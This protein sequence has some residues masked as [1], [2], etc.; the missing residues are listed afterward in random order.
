MCSL[1]ALGKKLATEGPH[2]V[3]GTRRRVRGLLG[4]KYVFD[5]TAAKYVWEHPY[6][7]SIFIL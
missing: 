3:E 5:T 2:K 6:C 4:G 1:E 7:S